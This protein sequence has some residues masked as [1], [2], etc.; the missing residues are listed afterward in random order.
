M[1]HDTPEWPS[2]NLEICEFN[3]S[4]FLLLS[5]EIPPDKG[6]LSKF[7]TRG[8]LL[9]TCFLTVY[10]NRAYFQDTTLDETIYY[11]QLSKVLSEKCAQPIGGLNLEVHI[12]NGSGSW[13][14]SCEFCG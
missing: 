2:K 13:A 7:S 8:F 14:P 3:P 12:S 9:Y 10:L 5:G 6:K 1:S 4:R 11:G